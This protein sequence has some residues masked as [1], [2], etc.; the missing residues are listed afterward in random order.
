V[1]PTIKSPIRVMRIIARMNV[2]GPAVQVSELMRGFD[3]VEFDHRLY[4][5]YCAPD[6]ADYLETV[7]TDVQAIRIDGFGRRVSLGGDIRAFSALVKEIRK[8][9]PNVIHTHTA[10]AGFLGRIASIISLQPSIR[11]HTFHGHLLNGYFGSFKRSLIVIVEKILAIFTDQLLAVGEKVRQD[12]LNAGV[13]KKEKFDLMPPGLVINKLPAKDETLKSFGLSDL[14]LQCAFIGRITQIKRPDRFLDVV[15]EVKK[16][17]I[18]LDFFMAGDG[19]LLEG[20]RKRI[21]DQKLP[22]TVLGWQSDIEKV[23]S[24]ADIVVLT[25]DNEGTPLSLIQAGMAGLPV[26]TTNVG[27][28]PEVVLDGVTGIITDL[29]VQEIANAL[30]KQATDKALRERLGLAAQEFTLANFGV[31]R[32][33]HDH[34]EL[35]KKLLAS[36]ARS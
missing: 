3:S 16:R 2:G 24:A 28:V 21:S 20:C 34:E 4:T 5:G 11:V 10:K 13:G 23:L 32:L 8:F 18:D 36:R 27:S 35:Y 15:S 12:L 6:E 29:D 30:Q 33:V 22:V 19:E 17:G 14:R 26:V 31:Q 9:K 1:N 25:S 7:A